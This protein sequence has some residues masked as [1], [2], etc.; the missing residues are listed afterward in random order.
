V[1]R[2]VWLIGLLAIAL[3]LGGCAGRKGESVEAEEAL[4][5]G[6]AM[7]ASPEAAEEREPTSISLPAVD[8]VIL[9]DGELVGTYPALDLAFPG[10]ASGALEALHVELGQHVQEGDLL[11][12]LDDLELRKAI[13]TAQRDLARAIEDQAKGKADI[14]R[15]YR[16]ELEDAQ[17]QYDRAT[18]DAERKY[19]RDLDEA[20][21]ALEQA[22]RD[23]QRLDMQ[24]PTTALAE[25]KVEL[26]RALDQEAKAADDYKQALDRPWED[27]EIRDSLYEEWQARIVDRELA[28]LRLQDARIALDVHRLDLEAR[29]QDIDNAA[30]DLERVEKDPVD[31]EVVD[32]EVNLALDRAVEDARLKLTE[33]EEDLEN[34]RLYAPWNG[35]VLSLEA[36]AGSTIDGGKTVITLLNIEEL[37]FVTENLSERHVAQLEH[38][39]HAEITLRTYP[40]VV[41]AG[42]VDVVLPQTERSSDSDARFVAY[43]RLE[44]SELDLLPGMTGRVQ[45]STGK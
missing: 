42:T 21:R 2:Q 14:D 24:P 10:S 22:R 8:D 26:G 3:L 20:R 27:Q 11:A 12:V 45:V 37:Y 1:K 29:K 13:A 16:R 39:Q 30:A 5:E 15:T 38:G 17:T 19:E 7:P 28:E 34:A 35:L 9:M 33:A 6:E 36:D 18:H 32:K 44:A 41:L 31:K 25:A 23:L 40:D 4:I 43:I